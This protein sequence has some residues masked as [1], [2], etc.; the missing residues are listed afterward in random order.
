MENSR[1]VTLVFVIA[2]IAA[3]VFVRSGANAFMVA[4]SIEDPLLGGM[5]PATMVVAVIAAVV[6]LF[7]LLRHEKARTFTDSVFHELKKVTWP[8]RDETTNNTG[9]VIAATVLFGGLLAVYD[10]AWA[11]VAEVVLYTDNK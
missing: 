6:T 5:A 10:Y 1:P 7:V 2:A 11:Q 4:R 3:G 8:T 9:I